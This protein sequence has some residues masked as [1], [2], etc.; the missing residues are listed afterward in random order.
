MRALISKTFGVILIVMIVA[1]VGIVGYSLKTG[2]SPIEVV[3]QVA[4]TVGGGVDAGTALPGQVTSLAQKTTAP[5]GETTFGK[6]SRMKIPFADRF[7]PG[8]IGL[9]EL[10]FYAITIVVFLGATLAIL[11]RWVWEKYNLDQK[12]NRFKTNVQGVVGDE[13]IVFLVRVGSL[14][15]LGYSSLSVATKDDFVTAATIGLSSL[16][17]FGG[18]FFVWGRVVSFFSPKVR[19]V[20]RD[21]LAVVAVVAL[22]VVL[23]SALPKALRSPYGIISPQSWGRYAP[24]ATVAYA[25]TGGFKV[26]GVLAVISAFIFWIAPKLPG[27]F[28]RGPAEV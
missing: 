13:P 18:L 9:G 4:R 15:S 25:M 11:R 10:P 20:L 1:T 22:I 5:L 6:A 26:E 16:V 28:E 3:K 14:L 12:W 8:G 23:V 21:V 19:D 17:I 2:S 27:I 24:V 7:V